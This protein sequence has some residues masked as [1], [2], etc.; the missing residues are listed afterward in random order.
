MAGNKRKRHLLGLLGVATQFIVRTTAESL[1]ALYDGTGF[2]A[3]YRNPGFTFEIL[4]KSE[5]LVIERLDINLEGVASEQIK[6]WSKP[7]VIGTPVALSTNEPVM[8][9]Y[10]EAGNTGW[11]LIQAFPGVVGQGKGSIT[12]LPAFNVPIVIPAGFKQ[13]FYVTASYTE[14]G[15]TFMHYDFGT[16]IGNA[17]ESNSDMDILEGCA[18]NHASVATRLVW[19]CPRLW[20]GIVHY[21]V[22]NAPT[23]SAPTD[24]L[25]PSDVPSS[26]TSPKPSSQPSS[27]PSTLPSGLPSVVL[28][29]DPSVNPSLFP[30]NAPSDDPSQSP[31]STV[32]QYVSSPLLF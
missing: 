26:Q 27:Q 28:S 4:A 29:S 25:M 5:A 21:S 2:T 3:P 23:T 17:Y 11:T 8:I 13:S 22:D 31:S 30:S 14:G 20:S 7:G 10:F 32:C 19:T 6:V 12:S 1:G 15:Q 18:V 16:V 9:P 24:S